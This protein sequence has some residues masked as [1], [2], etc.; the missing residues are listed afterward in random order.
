MTWY[1]VFIIS[2]GLS[3]DV[4]AYAMYK[5]AMISHLEAK[6]ITK[7]AVVFALWQ[8]VAMAVGSLIS[9]IPVMEEHYQRTE[10]LYDVLS[11]LILFAVGLIMIIRALKGKVITERREDNF[12]MKQLCIWAAITS[13]DSF[14]TGIS[15]GFL[16]TAVHML[17][18]QL[19]LITV[20][21]IIGGIFLGYRMG[22][23]M[24]Y[25]FVKLGGA[26]LLVAGMDVLLRYYG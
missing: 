6:K 2:I 22:C 12:Y 21:A 8:A 15:L 13:L 14:L 17:I 1:E 24:R 26:I 23:Q 4:F 18:I 11:A 25:G 10:K 19:V 16:N 20:A 7:M 3:L 5:G 9:E